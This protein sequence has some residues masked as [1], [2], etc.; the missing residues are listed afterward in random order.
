M[1]VALARQEKME[2]GVIS[3]KMPQ[4]HCTGLV[5][6][7]N[8]QLA[9]RECSFVSDGLLSELVWKPASGFLL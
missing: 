8:E 3:S 7:I 1:P 9:I 5:P 4:G 2:G 6:T